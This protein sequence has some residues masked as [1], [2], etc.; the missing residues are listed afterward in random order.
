MAKN[1]IRGIEAVV[2]IIQKKPLKKPELIK[3]ASFEEEGETFSILTNPWFSLIRENSE[4]ANLSAERE[5]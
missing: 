3:L 2:D 4:C 1:S 5:C